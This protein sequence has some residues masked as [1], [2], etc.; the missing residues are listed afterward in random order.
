MYRGGIGVSRPNKGRLRRKGRFWAGL[1]IAL[2]L[3]PAFAAAQ[4]QPPTAA[5]QNAPS[6]EFTA[7]QP[8]SPS[9]PRPRKPKSRDGI[10]QVLRFNEDW[11]FLKDPRQRTNAFDP[12]KYIPLGTLPDS[13]L[14]LFGDLRFRNINESTRNVQPKTSYLNFT[15]TRIDFGGDLHITRHFRSVVQLV[16]AYDVGNDIGTR[17]PSFQ[18]PLD[19][20][21]AFIEPMG[22]IGN[23]H[24]GMRIGREVI[25]MGN[26]TVIDINDFPDVEMAFDAVHPYVEIGNTKVEGFISDVVGQKAHTFQD[27]NNTT[28]KVNSLYVTHKYAIPSVFGAPFRGTIEP[29]FFDYHNSLGRYGSVSGGDTRRDYGIR[30]TENFSGWDFDDEFIYQG[31]RFANRS[32]GAWAFFST[33]GYT[34]RGLP[35][36]P[37]LGV[38]FDGASGGNSAHGSSIQTYQPMFPTAIYTCDMSF[39]APS[40]LI[41][42]RPSVTFHLTPKFTLQAWYGLF[43]RQN[44]KDAIYATAPVRAYG[45]TATTPVSGHLIGTVPQLFFSWDITPQVQL[46]QFASWLEPGHALQQAGGGKGDLFFATTLLFRF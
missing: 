35:F 32:V 11:T 5:E 15:G 7:S 10:Y 42:V 38:Q 3:S 21:Q 34:F 40:N 18:N 31:G 6:L 14:T 19:L 9:T 13:Y 1:G 20:L 41:D 39:F 17:P 30:L 12:L 8:P 36:S 22:D 46:S 4:S 23:A 29:F 45:T 37:R 33:Q 25:R 26:G 44:S 2:G 27:Y 16:S 28:V 43:Y 24:V